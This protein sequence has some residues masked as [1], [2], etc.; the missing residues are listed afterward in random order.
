M[1][2]EGIKTDREKTYK[3]LMQLPTGWRDDIPCDGVVMN[4]HAV[5]DQTLW[6]GDG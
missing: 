1:S 5:N 3:R 4:G 6:H 2:G